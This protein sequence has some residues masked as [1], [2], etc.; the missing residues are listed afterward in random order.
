MKNP[1]TSKQHQKPTKSV[2]VMESMGLSHVSGA[3]PKEKND[4]KPPVGEA[5]EAPFS[6]II[7]PQSSDPLSGLTVEQKSVIKSALEIYARLGMCQLDVLTDMARKGLIP[8]ADEISKSMKGATVTCFGQMMD[9]ARANMGFENC[10]DMSIFSDSV[11]QDSKVAWD[12]FKSLESPDEDRE[13][14]A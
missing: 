5:V 11:S 9:E 6:S 12:L 4:I 7:A 10:G 13:G 2:N 14:A 3:E 1:K 8:V